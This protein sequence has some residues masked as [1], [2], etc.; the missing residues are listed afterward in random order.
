MNLHW[1][2]MNFYDLFYI[3]VYETIKISHCTHSYKLPSNRLSPSS[4]L[5][6]T[7]PFLDHHP[8]DV[9]QQLETCPPP[10]MNTV[11]PSSWDSA[12]VMTCRSEARSLPD[13]S[14]QYQPALVCLCSRPPGC[15]KAS[16]S[17]L[18]APVPLKLLLWSH[19][20]VMEVCGLASSCWKMQGL[21]WNSLWMR[22][23]VCCSRP[24]C[25]FK[26]C[27]HTPNHQRCRLTLFFF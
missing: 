27:F 12:S 4:V 20:L 16:W 3:V 17:S 1:K 10:L 26:L 6:E 2:C 22:T 18:T 8:L 24:E 5:Q 11:L 7:L 9:P 15:W 21:L 25:V 14:H 19:V 23:C 13:W